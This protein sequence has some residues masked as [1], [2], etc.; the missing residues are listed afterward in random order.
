MVC[1]W[2]G[3]ARR[4]VVVT[5]FGARAVVACLPTPAPVGVADEFRSLRS[6]FVIVSVLPGVSHSVKSTGRL[7]L[8]EGGAKLL[9]RAARLSRISYRVSYML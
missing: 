5:A 8:L 9:R 6:R 4:C 3:E 2:S 7:G 1:G